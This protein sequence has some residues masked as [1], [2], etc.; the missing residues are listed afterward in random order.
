MLGFISLVRTHSI[1]RA[2]FRHRPDAAPGE[3]TLCYPAPGKIRTELVQCSELLFWEEAAP[4]PEKAVLPVIKKW[5]WLV[6]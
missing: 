3:N 5:A 2:G 6:L 1:R 4:K